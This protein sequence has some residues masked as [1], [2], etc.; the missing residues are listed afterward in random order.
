MSFQDFFQSI[1]APELRAIAEHWD[2]A[3]GDRRMPSWSAIDPVAIG[4][5]LRYV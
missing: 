1:A 3:R 2:H 5:H 4:R